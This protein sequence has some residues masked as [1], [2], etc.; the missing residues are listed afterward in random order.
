MDFQVEEP[1]I[2]DRTHASAGIA[3]DASAYFEGG[4]GDD[5]A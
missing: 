4:F 1:E 2:E 5:P 3:L